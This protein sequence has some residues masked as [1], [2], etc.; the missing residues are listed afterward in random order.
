MA[1]VI[2]RKVNPCIALASHKTENNTIAPIPIWTADAIKTRMIWS[3][4]SIGH[5]P[6]EGRRWVAI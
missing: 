5:H 1:E 3:L 2:A 6:C 4:I